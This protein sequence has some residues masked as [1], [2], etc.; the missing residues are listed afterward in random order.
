VIA[1]IALTQ[2]LAGERVLG[3][4]GLLI[5]LYTVA[6]YEPRRQALI[7]AGV[8]EVGVVLASI[9]FAPAGD[10]V[11]GSIVFLTGLLTGALFL[12]T[13]VRARRAYLESLEDRAYRLERERDS[14]AR[15]AVTE[16]RN[17][18]AREMHDIVAHSLS[19][20]ISLAD[21]AALTTDSDPA[22]A[23]TAMQAVSSTGRSALGEMRRLLG[24]LRDDD[25]RPGEERSPQPGLAQVEELLGSV[26][27][28]GMPVRYTV[29]GVPRTLPLTGQTAIYRV[30]QEALTN[31]LKHA[32]DVASVQVSMRW[33]ADCLDLDIRDDGERGVVPAATSVNGSD[34]GHGLTGMRERIAV[35]G[36]T[37]VAGPGPGRG[38]RVHAR[39]PIEEPA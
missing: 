6:A 23:R 25:D 5:A 8:L 31:V 7:C 34:S 14:Q 18:I 26:R 10:G 9:R 17:R 20:M 3:D 27:A 13:T 36:G 4:I 33:S 30:V 29:S 37:V 11:V 35:H 16:E 19:V 39:L 15:L 38:W 1:A 28:A 22:T 21:G 32:T 12:G 24:V 2:W